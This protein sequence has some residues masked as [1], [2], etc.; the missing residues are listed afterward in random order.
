MMITHIFQLINIEGLGIDRPSKS[1][2]YFRCF[3]KLFDFFATE[4]LRR[5]IKEGSKIFPY[6]D[7]LKISQRDNNHPEST[8]PHW[9]LCIKP[10]KPKIKSNINLIRSWFTVNLGRPVEN[11]EL[12]FYDEIKG[13]PDNETGYDLPHAVVERTIKLLEKLKDDSTGEHFV[14]DH[15]NTNNRSY[16]VIPKYPKKHQKHVDIDPCQVENEFIPVSRIKLGDASNCCNAIQDHLEKVDE[17]I[18]S[19][20]VL[21]D[22]LKALIKDGYSVKTTRKN[23][24]L[25]TSLNI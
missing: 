14:D 23:E 24:H 1:T 10:Y 5:K 12:Y 15:M 19:R 9:K 22:L 21:E 17:L 4:S 18:E 16:G 3:G 6:L 11:Y 13:C 25:T 20:L 8:T 7:N 2:T